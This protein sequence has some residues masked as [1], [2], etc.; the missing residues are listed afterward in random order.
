MLLVGVGRSLCLEKHAIDQDVANL[1][2]VE[3]LKLGPLAVP[4]RMNVCQTV[5]SSELVVRISSFYCFSV[6][7]PEYTFNSCHTLHYS[8]QRP[9]FG[10]AKSAVETP[11]IASPSRA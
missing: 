7:L 5:K 2:N 10:L 11:K 9:V 6:H 1:C 4:V 3:S 8:S